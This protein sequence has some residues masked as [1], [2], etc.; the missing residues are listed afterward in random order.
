[1]HNEPYNAGSTV[2]QEEEMS[3][4]VAHFVAW[5]K[6]KFCAKSLE[7]NA[8]LCAHGIRHC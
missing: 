5:G 8:P 7:Q 2:E 4:Y 3:S 1:M 6:H